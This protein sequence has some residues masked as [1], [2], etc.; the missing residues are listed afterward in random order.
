MGYV[1]HIVILLEVYVL[2]AVSAN[3]IIGY[4]GLLTLAHASLFA[5]GAYTYAILSLDPAW[6]FGVIALF[7]G[8]GGGLMGL[9]L[10]LPA[11]RMRGDFFVMASLAFQALV[12]SAL[13]NWADPSAPTGTWS[14]LTNGPLGVSGVSVPIVFGFK[15][16]SLAERT[17][18]YTLVSAACLAV[19]HVFTKAPW[20]LTLQAIRDDRL[21]ARSLGKNVKGFEA[22]A[23]SLAGV[24]AGIAGC[25]YATH[26]RFVDPSVGSLNESILIL[27]MVVVGGVGNFAGPITGAVVLVLLPEVLRWFE[28][29]QS[30]AA[31]LRLSIYG[32][33]LLLFVHF[34]PN[35]LAGHYRLE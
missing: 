21:V 6:S 22:E 18:L 4:C 20:G 26:L 7:C 12:Y 27:C 3:L 13:M 8:I 25:M 16:S 9:V 19:C 35:G 29:P 17:I 5:V 33:L 11:W 2:V 14:N 31:E 24:V 30:V 23:F 32:I 10:V 34:R 15:V 28:V 1:F